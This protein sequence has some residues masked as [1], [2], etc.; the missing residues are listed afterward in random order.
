MDKNT[1]SNTIVGYNQEA[2]PMQQ[3]RATVF[4]SRIIKKQRGR[5]TVFPSR[6]IK[7]HHP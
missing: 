5:A 4:P 7:K 1:L 6:I 3:R 2:P